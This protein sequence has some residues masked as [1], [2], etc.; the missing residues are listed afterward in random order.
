MKDTT[1]IPTTIPQRKPRSGRR[2]ILGAALLVTITAALIFFLSSS[3]P[4]TSHFTQPPSPVIAEE[5]EQ[6]TPPAIERLIELRNEFRDDAP[7]F[8]CISETGTAY[9]TNAPSLDSLFAVKTSH[10]TLSGGGESI[11]WNEPECKLVVVVDSP[12]W[13]NLTATVQNVTAEFGIGDVDL[14][15]NG[16]HQ[17]AVTVLSSEEDTY[18]GIGRLIAAASRAHQ[19]TGSHPAAI[20]LPVDESVVQETLD[21]LKTA[22]SV[23][24]ETLREM[25][26]S[27]AAVEAAVQLLTASQTV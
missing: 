12:E 23:D 19:G 5:K 22:S 20:N 13:V 25:V 1:P 7:R 15:A 10:T 9:L 18:Q 11:I 4:A 26:V 2:I 14:N 24:D 8:S 16:I 27:D 6:A 3:S 17:I 21:L